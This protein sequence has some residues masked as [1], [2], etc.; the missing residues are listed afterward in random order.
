VKR[1]RLSIV[2]LVLTVSCGPCVLPNTDPQVQ[3]LRRLHQQFAAA[4]KARMLEVQSDALKVTEGID[5]RKLPSDL[6]PW[7]HNLRAY[8]LS[9]TH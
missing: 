5:E 6:R 2:A 1:L 7:I 3:I 4:N 8:G 9:F